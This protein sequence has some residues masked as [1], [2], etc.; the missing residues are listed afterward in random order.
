VTTPSI[1]AL[2]LLAAALAGCHSARTPPAPP[3]P[4]AT[5][6]AEPSLLELLQSAGTPALQPYLDAYPLGDQGS[7]VDLLAS[8]EKRSMHFVQV[9]RATPRHTY[10]A[11]TETVYVLTGSGTCYIGDRSY[12]IQPG[13]AF[14]I[15]PGVPRTS[16]PD[17]GRTIVA[18]SYFEPPLTGD[19]DRVSVP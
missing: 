2:T 3:P 13:S 7:R 6:A 11:R 16:L 19:D 5:A 12:P 4:P 1:A 15:A 10:A 14:R 8:D 17:E 9:R 18:I